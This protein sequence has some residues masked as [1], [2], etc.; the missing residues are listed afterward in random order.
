M[1][2]RRLLDFRSR[3]GI[4]EF[5]ILMLRCAVFGFS[6]TTIYDNSDGS[7]FF[8]ILISSVYLFGAVVIWRSIIARNRDI[9]YP[10]SRIVHLIIPIINIIYV[11]DLFTRKSKS[12]TH[13]GA[14]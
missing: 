11:Y 3:C 5:Y 4:S 6:V 8:G 14:C 1:D 7:F 10:T 12:V 2:V 9:G 13:S